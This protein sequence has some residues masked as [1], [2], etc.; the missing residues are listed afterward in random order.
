MKGSLLNGKNRQFFR[1]IDTL[2]G[3]AKL[4]DLIGSMKRR[5]PANQSHLSP[6]VVK[7]LAPERDVGTTL[8]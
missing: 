8:N 6:S 4:E 1:R 5:I 2:D 7:L 3:A